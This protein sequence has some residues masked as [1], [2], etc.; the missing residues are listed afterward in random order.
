MIRTFSIFVVAVL[1]SFAASAQTQIAA[2]DLALD[3]V[4]QL[5]ARQL[6]TL[7]A[8]ANSPQ[9]HEVLASYYRARA[10]EYRA[11]AEAHDSMLNLFQASDIMHNDKLRPG[12]ID[13]CLHMARSLKQRAE[14]AQALAR[15]QQQMAQAARA[16][17][18]GD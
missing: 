8:T 13:H 4:P 1:S 10:I 18:Q 17:Q 3:A 11:Q 6:Q 9:D 15:D 7:V 5:S 14:K 16:R 12:T 2:S